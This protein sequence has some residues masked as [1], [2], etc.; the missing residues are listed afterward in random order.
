MLR[1]SELPG[2]AIPSTRSSAG[3]TALRDLA[4]ETGAARRRRCRTNPYRLG[5]PKARSA[6]RLRAGAR[7]R[8]ARAAAGLGRARLRRAVLDRRAR[9]RLLGPR[10]RARRARGRAGRRARV[11]APADLAALDLASRLLGE[12]A[13]AARRDRRDQPGGSAGSGSPRAALAATGSRARPFSRR[14]SCC[15]ARSRSA[16]SRRSRRTWNPRSRRSG[17]GAERDR[18]PHS[19]L[20]ERAML[21]RIRAA[22][23]RPLRQGGLGRRPQPASRAR[24]NRRISASSVARSSTPIRL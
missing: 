15:A 18:R 23:C 10:G 2:R 17:S 11:G 21:A 13:A 5:S 19:R 24:Q 3:L 20:R 8:P 22:S 1:R 9:G 12:G 14:T 4:A 6:H 7:R 16:R